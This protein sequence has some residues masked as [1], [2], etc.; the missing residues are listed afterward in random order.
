MPVPKEGITLRDASG[1]VCDLDDVIAEARRTPARVIIDDELSVAV[2]LTGLGYTTSSMDWKAGAG[3][4]AP[5][6][7]LRKRKKP[8]Q[9]L[10][11]TTA[12]GVAVDAAVDTLFHVRDANGVIKHVRADMLKPGM[13]IAHI[14]KDDGTPGFV[15]Y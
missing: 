10:R 8:T 11:I 12:S 2:D 15:V 13:A 9:I 4:N 14:E 5:V 1:Q 6:S 7:V 3:V